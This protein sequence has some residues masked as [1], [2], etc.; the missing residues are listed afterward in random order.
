MRDQLDD[1]LAR[2]TVVERAPDVAADLV[3]TVERGERGDGDEAAVAL[4]EPRALPHVAEHDLVG[5]LAQP[6]KD[7]G[8]APRHPHTSPSPPWW[9]SS[10]SSGRTS[11]TCPMVEG[12]AMLF[13]GELTGADSTGVYSASL[14]GAFFCASRLIRPSMP[15]CLRM[16]SNSVR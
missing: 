6:R 3:G 2:H 12:A 13:S 11:R 16:P 10:P 1:L 15:S 8:D 4:G 7:V 14:G 5:E 9:L